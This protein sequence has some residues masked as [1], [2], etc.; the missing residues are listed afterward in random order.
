M[1]GYNDYR[2]ISIIAVISLYDPSSVSLA[3]NYQLLLFVLTK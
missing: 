1:I 3:I 2:I